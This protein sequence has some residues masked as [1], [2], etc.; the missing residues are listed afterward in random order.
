M[1]AGC[2]DWRLWLGLLL[3]ATNGVLA[4]TT[5]A[6]ATLR[7]GTSGDYA[8][9]SLREADGTHRGFSIDLA[10][11]YAEDRGLELE[12]VPFQWP[13]LL[14]ALAKD[15]FDLALSG[16][17]VRP[18]RSIAGRFSLP[19]METGAVV[20]LRG[21][22]WG[23]LEG[24]DQ[25]VVRIGVNAG[26]HL[27]RVAAER[28][29][30]ATRVA[31]PDNAAVLQA[32]L[33]GTVQAV[34][35]DSAEAPSWL[36]ALPPDY[37]T[38]GP[39]T[40]DRKAALVAPSRSDLAVDFDAWLA[41]RER[42]GTLD[43]LRATHFGPGPWPRTAEPLDALLA[44]VDER[45][46]LMPTVAVVK[47]RSGVPLEV[48]ERESKV[49]DAA[50]A[51]VAAAADATRAEP[52]D[53]LLVRAFFR[54]QMEAAKAVQRQTVKSDFDVAEPLPSLDDALRPSLLRIGDRAARLLLGLQPPAAS[55]PEAPRSL[56]ARTEAAVRAPYVPGS[57]R[58]S[59]ARAI[60]ALLQAQPKAM[61]ADTPVPTP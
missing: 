1:R 30:R 17:T 33:D 51:S 27:E 20:I 5:D 42:D 45:L 28:F 2:F 60:E 11:R 31:I 8:P 56:V 26:G 41:L 53:P 34:V 32:L 47:R 38:H 35:T 10:K 24:L 21:D 59:I 25:P 18:E 7:V 48:P 12:L 49:L 13:S 29:P 3:V 4:E 23:G 9:F 16:I 19:V 15:R 43:A 44:A 54:A 46:A 52:P 58:R 37:A 6:D 36:A 61:P 14:D 39:F 40:R 50:A 22:D 55:D 57:S